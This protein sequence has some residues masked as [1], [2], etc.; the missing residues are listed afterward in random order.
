MSGNVF[1]DENGQSLTQR[2]K[3]EDI[4]PTIEWVEQFTGL[5]LKDAKLGTTGKKSTSGDVDLAV[6]AS[7]VDKKEFAESIKLR[8]PLA[9]GD[10]IKNWI[11]LSGTSVHIRAPIA[12]D[13]DRGYVQVDLMFGDPEWMK[14]THAGAT[15]PGSLYKGSHRAILMSSIAKAKGA[16]WSQRDG[17]VSRTTKQVIS[18]DP[19]GVAMFLLGS[20]ATADHLMDV[21]SILANILHDPGYEFLM[22]DA[23]ENFE[24]EG[25]TLPTLKN[26][27]TFDAF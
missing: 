12:G 1:K 20:Y 22:A 25:L 7:V 4:D 23:R 14:F 21:E 26:E 6:D 2:I 15:I 5:K 27:E 17:L 3:R 24:R 13:P 18:K 16:K 8:W 11:K 10:D 9:R 19:D